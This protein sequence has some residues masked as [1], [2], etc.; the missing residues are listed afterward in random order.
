MLV[1]VSGDSGGG[2]SDRDSE[3]GGCGTFRYSKL[4]KPVSP[5][6]V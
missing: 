6:T 3:G 1:T 2:G 4:V 5:G